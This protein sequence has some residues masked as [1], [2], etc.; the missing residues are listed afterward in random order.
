MLVWLCILL[1]QKLLGQDVAEISERLL[2][3]VLPRADRFAVIDG[4]IPVAEGYRF[5]GETGE[6]LVGYVFVTSDV[7][8]EPFGYSGPVQALVGMD[9]EGS[10][11]GVRV[12]DYWES[13][14]ES[15]GDFLRRPGFQ[16]HFSGKHI[17]D[18][19]RVYGD[20]QGI[21]RATISVRALSR[22]VRD[23]A[24]RV[25]LLYLDDQGAAPGPV[26]DL[27]SLPWFDMLQRGVIGSTLLNDET[28]T[29]EIFL[30]YA[31]SEEF[32]EFL[33]GPERF[34]RARTRMERRDESGHLMI[35]GVEG[36]R[37]RLFVREGWAVVQD[38]DT[39]PVSPREI[40]SLGL[41]GGGIM[42]ERV[43]L[44]GSMIIDGNIDVTKAFTFV[45]D[46]DSDIEPITVEY[47]TQS[48]Q[49]AEFDIEESEKVQVAEEEITTATEVNE[50]SLDSEI[51]EIESSTAI[52]VGQ[53]DDTTDLASSI[54]MPSG[55]SVVLNESDNLLL[56]FNELKEETFLERILLETSWARVGKLA[57]LFSLVLI[58]FF[59][60]K[61]WIK[62]FTLGLTLLYLGFADGGFL[63][64]S[65]ITSGIW[66][67]PSFYLS[68]LPLL[69]LVMFTLITT[70]LWGRVFCG[71]LCPFGVLQDLLEKVVPKR[72]RP[73][74]PTKVHKSGLKLKYVFLAIIVVS[75][76]SG[77]RVS[78]YQYF[79]P[80]GTVFFRSSSL[81][82]WAIALFFL[83][84][85]LVVPRFYCR[86]ACPLGAALA[87]T[88]L[89]SLKRIKRVEQCES[90]Y[91]CEQDC[92]TGAIEGPKIDFKECVRCNVCEINLIEKSGV[93]RHEVQDVRD[94]LVP[95]TPKIT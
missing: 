26:E 23:S 58:A 69:M 85:S 7:P 9:L 35:Y 17:G 37:L 14:Q 93:C 55:E 57:G 47:L 74:I 46:R 50:F 86:Y 51:F 25:A 34:E 71:F 87:L 81:T 63:S 13:I 84:I 61:S 15:M 77:S 31:E 43:V 19:F 48:A 92:P 91:V 53:E 36:P 5:G 59:V 24:R 89:L 1:P 10:L 42:E 8:P 33:V 4:A 80:F 29:A 6:R 45:Y 68:D 49:L 95:L 18:A 28:G 12:M 79:E 39:F 78:L 38:G 90:C 52:E 30:V 66:V 3:E 21:S 94:R 70:L 11:T 62:S 2:K 72:L 40:A 56:E 27:E 73:S 20:V 67:G 16:E 32:G 82:L 41:D 44:T 83:G 60:K 88:S 64:V 22:G 75:A 65:H 76:A 54:Q